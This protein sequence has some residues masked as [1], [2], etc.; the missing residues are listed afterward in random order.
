MRLDTFLLADAVATGNSRVYIHGGSITRLE[1]PAL[2]FPVGQ[3]AV[4]ARLKPDDDAELERS[5]AMRLVV[6]GPTGNPNIPP[7]NFTLPAAEL[8]ELLPGEERLVDL[9]LNFGGVT[10]LREGLHR[11]ELYYDHQR[12]GNAPLP[13][14]LVPPP[15]GN[16][17]I[18]QAG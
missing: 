14:R 13:A 12:I 5:H 17:Q 9:A 10:I 6:V 11:V 3:L 1:V 16:G 2:P 4:Y 18:V 8:P 15:G 7:L